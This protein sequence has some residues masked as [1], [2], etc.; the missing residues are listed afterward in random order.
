MAV[1]KGLYD[2]MGQSLFPREYDNFTFKVC[3]AHPEGLGAWVETSAR[4]DAAA[5]A[6]HTT[7]CGREGSRDGLARAV[8][9][10]W[11]RCMS[12]KSGL[13]GPGG[14]RGGGRRARE[15]EVITRCGVRAFDFPIDA[16]HATAACRSRVSPM[17]G[18][19][20]VARGATARE[21][22]GAM[23]LRVEA[24]DLRLRQVLPERGAFPLTRGEGC[25]RR[26][27]GVAQRLQRDL[28][29]P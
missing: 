3:G 6:V 20:K 17:S 8:Q 10:P 22:R 15:R 2:D 29:V 11:G 28:F 7:V 19:R 13:S 25:I 14:W 27:H 12:S 4:S 16:L 24:A 1:A 9:R 21:R 26:V 23:C 5:Q 18:P